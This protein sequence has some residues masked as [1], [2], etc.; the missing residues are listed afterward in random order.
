MEQMPL[1][2]I[3]SLVILVLFGM[4]LIGFTVYCYVQT[5]DKNALIEEVTRKRALEKDD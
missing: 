5:R 3:V 1:W 4:V 2:V